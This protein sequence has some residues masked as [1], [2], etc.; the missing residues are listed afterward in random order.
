MPVF[1]EFQMI[2][3]FQMKSPHGLLVNKKQDSYK[4]SVKGENELN[5]SRVFITRLLLFIHRF[6]HISTRNNPD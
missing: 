3:E 4:Q 5:I 1:S 2:I 6:K